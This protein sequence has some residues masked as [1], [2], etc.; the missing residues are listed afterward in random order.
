MPT[1]PGH[2]LTDGHGQIV[3]V[4]VSDGEVWVGRY[5]APAGH[6]HATL[7]D[8]QSYPIHGLDPDRVRIAVVRAV[9]H[10][11]ITPA[12]QNGASLPDGDWI[13][14]VPRFLRKGVA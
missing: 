13:P 7:Y 12:R 3:T 14:A 5:V 8:L 4:T 1:H 10:T 9:I 2:V 6:N 11:I